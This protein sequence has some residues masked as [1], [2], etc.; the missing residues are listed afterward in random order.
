MSPTKD[1][2]VG[3]ALLEYLRKE[4]RKNWPEVLA[5]VTTTEEEGR[6]IYSVRLPQLTRITEYQLEELR[7]HRR[8]VDFFKKILEEETGK[9]AVPVF[10]P[11]IL[12][13]ADFRAPRPYRYN[14]STWVFITE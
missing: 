4:M 7:G 8:A 11:G 12:N 2:G 6:M 13:H 1:T 5:E 14:G 9:K 10:S 3:D